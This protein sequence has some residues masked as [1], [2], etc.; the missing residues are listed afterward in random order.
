MEHVYTN[1]FT[2]V[3]AGSE[4]NFRFDMLVPNYDEAGQ[5]TNT[6]KVEKS[7]GVT[8]TKETAKSFLEKLK[9][10]MEQN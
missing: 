7:C 9:E 4:M 10:S 8:M 2:I 6:P 5:F 1:K 3:D